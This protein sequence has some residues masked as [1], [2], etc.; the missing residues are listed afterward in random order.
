MHLEVPPSQPEFIRLQFHGRS[1]DYFSIWIVNLFLTLVTLGVYSPWAKIRKMKY[2]N[3]ATEFKG[4]RM[5]YHAQPLPILIGRIIALVI[6]GLYFW[7]GQINWTVG[8]LG[9]F[10][11]VLVG[12]F[13]FV[14]S[15]RFK[16]KY[17]SYRNV[18][19]GFHG[20]LDDAYRLWF[21]YGAFL[22]VTSFISILCLKI[23]GQLPVTT[24]KDK[25]A[26]LA[27]WSHPTMI[28]IMSIAVVNII[29]MLIMGRKI[30]NAS[31]SYIYNNLSYGG[32]R[33][34]IHTDSSAVFSHVFMPYLRAI[35]WMVLIAL[36]VVACLGLIRITGTIM[37]I[38]IVPL[39]FTFYG[40]IFYLSVLFPY[41]TNTYIWGRLHAGPYQSRIVLS[42]KDFVWVVFTNLFVMIFSFGLMIPWAQMRYR[43]LLTE[44]KYLSVDNL[45]QFVETAASSASPIAEEILGIFDLDFEIG[46]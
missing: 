28:T 43:K 33:V 29:Y 11:M 18:R 20:K 40:L 7:G 36:T 27:I 16:T 37:L 13:L 5:D 41:L 45:D 24:G 3:Q 34:S 38:L 19:F 6:F 31:Y 1:G 9:F 35:G 42:K 26:A 32:T 22:F 39:I 10:L 12:P 21:R 15:M 44:S 23:F 14:K 8:I 25:A 2:I 4:S 46:L 30:L 17:T